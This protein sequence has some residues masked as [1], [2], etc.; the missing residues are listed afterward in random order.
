MCARLSFTN[1]QKEDSLAPQDIFLLS[2]LPDRLLTKVVC[3][4]LDLT[5]ENKRKHV[6]STDT[7]DSADPTNPTAFK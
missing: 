1:C 2:S 3:N 6:H 5:A 7:T 4:K